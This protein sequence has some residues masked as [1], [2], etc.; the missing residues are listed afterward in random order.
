MFLHGSRFRPPAGI[1]RLSSNSG[2]SSGA[3]TTVRSISAPSYKQLP[4][5]RW[6][7]PLAGGN[8]TVFRRA[9]P[10]SG[11]SIQ[12]SSSMASPTTPRR[13]SCGKS[14]AAARRAGVSVGGV[15]GNT[16][17]ARSLHREYASLRTYCGP[18]NSQLLSHAPRRPR[19]HR[20]RRFG[21]KMASTNG[22]RPETRPRH[23]RR[24]NA[25]QK[26]MQ[27][28]VCSAARSGGH[29]GGLYEPPRR[30]SRCST[31]KPRR[32]KVKI[33]GYEL[34]ENWGD[35]FRVE[36]GVLTRWL[37]PL[38]SPTT[39]SAICST[40]PFQLHPAVEYRFVG[41][42]PR[43]SRLAFRNN[44]IAHGQPPE[45]MG[46]DQSFPVSIEVQ[47][48]GG[49]GQGAGRRPTSARPPFRA[50]RQ[51]DYAHCNNSSSKTYHGDHG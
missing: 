20:L 34:G 10:K 16:R 15:A 6:R 33:K 14:P 46:K 25:M 19:R 29:G 7:W 22:N 44:G 17:T 50:E 18:T 30:G 26:I 38:R 5:S 42:Q 11:I 35:T 8:H 21:K 31:A 24:G 1:R 45:T 2:R 9:R 36:D 32:R 49:S 40:K 23:R 39:D 3:C 27:R 43:R 51:T 13:S 41:Q 37:R 47:L 28:P 12:G 4:D 48:L